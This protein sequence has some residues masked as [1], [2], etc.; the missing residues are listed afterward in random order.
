MKKTEK[1]TTAFK[2]IIFFTNKPDGS[3]YTPK[4]ME[5]LEHRKYIGSFDTRRG[6]FKHKIT[7]LQEAFRKQEY[8][9]RNSYNGKYTT[10]FVV[11]NNYKGFTVVLR[12]YVYDIFKAGMS[13]EFIT[14]DSKK[15]S[16]DIYNIPTANELIRKYY[17]N[18]LTVEEKKLIK[19]VDETMP[20]ALPFYTKGATY[21]EKLKIHQFMTEKNVENSQIS[22][23]GLA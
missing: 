19:P 3:P 14:T 8:L 7:D 5:N 2:I 21:A 18:E 20:T 4:E 12:K 1:F 16:T 10:A 9:I 11:C 23:G 22:S 6:K 13:V 15:G 17:A